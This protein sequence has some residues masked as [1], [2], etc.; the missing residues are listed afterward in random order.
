MLLFASFGGQVPTQD[1]VNTRSL[2]LQLVSVIVG[3]A[4]FTF[5][6]STGATPGMRLFRLRVVDADSSQPI[7]VG[8]ALL[9]Y[10]GY[11]VSVACCYLGLIW[12]AFDGRKQGWHD[13]LAGTVVVY[14]SGR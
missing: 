2:P 7:G 14:A 11:V 5:F 1:E 8:R 13:K 12:A 6:W 10:V 4:Y 3:A 9:R